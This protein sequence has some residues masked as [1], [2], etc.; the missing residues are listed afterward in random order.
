MSRNTNNRIFSNRY[1]TALVVVALAATSVLLAAGWLQ[2]VAA[3]GGDGSV[4]GV[5]VGVNR[6]Q[7]IRLTIRS[8]HDPISYSSATY[9]QVGNLIH[10]TPPQRV[11][12][13]EFRYSD[14]CRRDLH[15]EGEPDTGRLQVLV[16]LVI[17]LPAG[18]EPSDVKTSM[19]II[20]EETGATT[21][22]FTGLE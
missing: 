6:G 11:P 18:T 21:V 5:S 1:V 2:P 3:N 7:T 14:I 13:G 4:R 12:A 19:E 8:T 20:N 16:K 22:L 9:D 10:A 15:A 17:E